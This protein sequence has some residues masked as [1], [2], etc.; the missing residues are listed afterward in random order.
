MVLLS[1]DRR[2]LC[3][4]LAFIVE[5]SLALMRA[6]AYMKFTCSGVFAQ[7]DLL[8]FV[9]SSPFSTA[10]L[11]VPSFGIWHIAKFIYS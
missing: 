5:L 9:V 11:G 6:M 1:L 4:Q 10:L 3:Y 2:F 8:C 7:G